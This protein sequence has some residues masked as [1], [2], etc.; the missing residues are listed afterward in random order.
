MAGS[1]DEEVIVVDGI[2]VLP[3]KMSL[4]VVAVDV[5]PHKISDS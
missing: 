1:R 3:C 2:D 5:L 4:I